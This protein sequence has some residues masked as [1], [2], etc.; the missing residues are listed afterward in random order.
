MCVTL[1][2]CLTTHTPATLTGYAFSV[3]VNDTEAPGISC[4]APIVASTDAGQCSKTNVTY[5]A[6]PT[7][8]C[9]GATVGCILDSGSTFN[10]G[11]TRVSCLATD[12]SCNTNGC[13]F[14]VTINDTEAPG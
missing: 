5:T 9:P 14:T 2:G 12:S 11:V 8:N 7:D 13:M 10:K 4:P 6:T 3:T 1:L